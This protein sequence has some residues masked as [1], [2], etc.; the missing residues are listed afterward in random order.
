M[1]SNYKLNMRFFIRTVIFS[2]IVLSGLVV[3][4]NAQQVR[5]IGEAV[6]RGEG[7]LAISITSSDARVEQFARRAFA[8]HGGFVISEAD[9]AS[10]NF[11]FEPSSTSSA[12]LSVG[13]GR[14]LQVQLSREVYGSDFQNAILRACDV[15]VEATLGIKGF[16]GGK[17][18]FV[19]KQR[20]LSELY[21]SDL[22]FSRVRPLT[23]D[24]SLVTG[25]SW[26]PDGQ[27]LLFTTYYKSGFPDI[28]MIDLTAGLKSPIATFKGTNT[29][30]EISPDGSQIAMTL[31][32]PD[33]TELYVSDS[34]GKNIRRITRNKS[35][36]SSP[37]WS[38]DGRK[39]IFESDAAG[40]PQLYLTSAAGGASMQRLPTNIS[41]YCSEPCWNP[42]QTNLIAFTVAVRGGFQ[43]AIYDLDT[44]QSRIL[45]SQSGS[46]LEPE[47]L[48]DGR[49]LICT[50]RQG[51]RS[52]LALVDSKTGAVKPLHQSSFGDAS[53]ASFVY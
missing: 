26:S 45:T 52:S 21:M 15:A 39:L 10:F 25:P 49:H 44:R 38:P 42:V 50:L 48:N 53:S 36:E 24:R 7:R 32:G 19:G 9:S 13:S 8:L 31:S 23:A 46:A 27:K 30:G 35:L 22:L 33:G 51:G 18:A 40:K 20:G 41:S 43:I 1:I 16:F 37:A 5:D 2:F 11:N 12:R 6:R 34:N 4:V 47:W 3:S 14:P 28:Y 29:G 17:L